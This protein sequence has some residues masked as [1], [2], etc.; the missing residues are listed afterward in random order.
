MKPT[1]DKLGAEYEDS[2]TVLIGDVDCTIEKDVCSKFGVRG[3]PTI[4]Y[5][6]GNTAADGDDYEGG[7]DYDSLK[8]FIDENLGPSCGPSNKDLCDEDQLAAIAEVE[9]MSAEDID[10]A[11]KA[12][13]D[14]IAKADEDFKAAVDD[15]QAQYKK[16]MEDKDAT[17]AE[18]QAAK[19]SVGIL[20]G[21]L[22]AKKEGAS[23]HD[24]L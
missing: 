20:R 2:K 5:F 23:G 10:A 1:W 14:T 22:K 12:K 11:I 19:P 6:T 17:I 7:R 3:Y 15:L 16:L 24:E 13:T 18:L 21:V 9:K 8:T 4:K